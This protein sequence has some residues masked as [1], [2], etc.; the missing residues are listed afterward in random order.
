MQSGA[1]LA[2]EAI[3]EYLIPRAADLSARLQM[4]FNC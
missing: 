4:R 1:S 2:A 3:F